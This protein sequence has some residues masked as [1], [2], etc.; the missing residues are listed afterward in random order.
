MILL[1][2]QVFIRLAIF[3]YAASLQHL[4]H[5][6]QLTLF[7]LLTVTQTGCNAIFAANLGMRFFDSNLL[8]EV[9]GGRFFKTAASL[10]YYV[11]LY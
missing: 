9:N 2:Q 6:T 10:Y 7:I 1:F 8:Y 4:T 5:S 11:H 3:P